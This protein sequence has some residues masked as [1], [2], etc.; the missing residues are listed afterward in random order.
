[1]S[2]SAQV[3]KESGPVAVARCIK[4][5]ILA[6]NIQAG[7]KLPTQ[8]ELQKH[9]RIGLRRLR[10]GMSILEQ[11]GVVVRRRK[12]GTVVMD[13]AVSE[14]VEPISWQLLRRSCTPANLLEARVAIES[15]AVMLACK[16]HRSRDLL[17]MLDTIEQMEDLLDDAAA[18]DLIEALDRK[19]HHAILDATHNPAMLVFGQLL[20][21]Q[22]FAGPS[23]PCL[24]SPETR[25]RVTDEHRAIAEVIQAGDLA[26]AV[27]LTRS[28]LLAGS[29]SDDQ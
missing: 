27:A 9:F 18:Q 28:H 10:E 19:F 26:Q 15:E 4:E 22:F 1:M 3:I 6:N 2:R 21:A 7:S 24:D 12:G 20:R 23:H 14:L 17:A 8:E 13:P 5:Y 16:R 29:D 11:E 25:K